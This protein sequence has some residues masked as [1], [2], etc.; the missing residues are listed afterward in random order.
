MRSCDELLIL[1]CEKSRGSSW[2]VGFLGVRQIFGGAFFSVTLLWKWAA[3][4]VKLD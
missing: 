2:L 3:A 4:G 1:R